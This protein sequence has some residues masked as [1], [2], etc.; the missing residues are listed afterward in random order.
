MQDDAIHQSDPG[1]EEFIAEEMD[2]IGQRA[3]K[4]GIC[5]DCLTD[6]FIVE[7]VAT[8]ARSG[9]PASEILGMVADGLA[10]AENQDVGTG[11]SAPHRMH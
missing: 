1:F 4:R 10:L 3:Q 2:R 11:T 6:R 9:L 7:M 5:T 8:L